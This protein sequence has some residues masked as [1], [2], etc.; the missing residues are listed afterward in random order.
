MTLPVLGGIS[1]WTRTI[2]NIARGTTNDPVDDALRAGLFQRARELVER[3]AGGHH[4]V[5]HRD[6]LPGERALAA[7]CAAHVAPARFAVEAGLRRRVALAHARI[8]LELAAEVACDL[9]RLVVAPLAQTLRRKRH[10][11]DAVDGLPDSLLEE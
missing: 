7:E 2:S 1:G 3:R 11:N 10:G 5:D 6:P 8:D 9:H 4:I